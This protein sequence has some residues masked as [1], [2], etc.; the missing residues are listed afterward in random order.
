MIAQVPQNASA[1]RARI[2]PRNIRA[3]HTSGAMSRTRRNIRAMRVAQ[4]TTALRQPAVKMLQARC[5]WCIPLPRRA[6]RPEQCC[7]RGSSTS[8][9]QCAHLMPE[10]PCGR[11]VNPIS[12]P[13][14]VLTRPG[15]GSLTITISAALHKSRT[16]SQMRNA[17][18]VIDIAP[19][20]LKPEPFVERQRIGLRPKPGDCVA[21]PFEDLQRR[22]G[23][24]PLAQPR[25]A[26]RSRT[27]RKP[28]RSLPLILL[29]IYP[30]CPRGDIINK[31][32]ITDAGTVRVQPVDLI[33]FSDTPCS[34]MNTIRAA[35][36]RQV[37][38]SSVRST[39]AL[40]QNSP[41]KCAHRS[42]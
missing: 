17:C 8:A 5:G 15:R 2:D 4:I 9:Q 38:R 3:D 37:A 16:M 23:S 26:E 19:T 18:V 11:H 34:S 31:S 32:A 24:D 40:M 10:P 7:Q 29:Q 6:K 35:D 13:R 30:G 39:V 27:K 41:A 42:P 20:A 25:A 28:V 36:A 21:R 33:R 1:T 12:R 22:C 14:R